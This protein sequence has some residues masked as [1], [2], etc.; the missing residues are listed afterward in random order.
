MSVDL[1]FLFY[2]SFTGFRSCLTTRCFMS[3]GGVGGLLPCLFFCFFLS[4]PHTP[5][6][7]AAAQAAKRAEREMLTTVSRMRGRPASKEEP[8]KKSNAMRPP[9]EL[10]EEEKVRRQ[11]RQVGQQQRQ[12]HRSLCLCLSVC[13]CVSLVPCDVLYDHVSLFFLF[14]FFS[15]ESKQKEKAERNASMK[16]AE[17]EQKSI[18][19]EIAK[20]VHLLLMLISITSLTDQHR[21][22][23][24]VC[25]YTRDALRDQNG[26][27]NGFTDFEI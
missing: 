1:T 23:M 18:K 3:C 14:L 11:L 2:V 6:Q 13:L 20:Q 12:Q 10:S 17:A 9:K 21:G 24:Y 4:P 8:K 25:M 27:P 22:Y 7:V 5:H 26:S 19:D 16:V 15:Q